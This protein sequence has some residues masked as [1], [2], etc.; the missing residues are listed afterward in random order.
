MILCL[1]CTCL[2]EIIRSWCN[3]SVFLQNYNYIHF[4]ILQYFLFSSFNIPKCISRLSLPSLCEPRYNRDDGLLLFGLKPV[5]SMVTVL[6]SSVLTC[7]KINTFCGRLCIF[8]LLTAIHNVKFWILLKS[9]VWFMHQD[10]F[11]EIVNFFTASFI[12]SGWFI[13]FLKFLFSFV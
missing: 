12:V 8:L 1:F 13:D 11:V 9:F 5:F 10:G 6:I 2:W 4:K 3:R 7:S